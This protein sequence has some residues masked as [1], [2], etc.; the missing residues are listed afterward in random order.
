MILVE[1]MKKVSK[2]RYAMIMMGERL[3]DKLFILAIYISY[4]Y[5]CQERPTDAIA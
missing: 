3:E 1:I 5:A 2:Y 4:R